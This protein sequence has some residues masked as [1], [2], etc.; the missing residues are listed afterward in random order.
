MSDEDLRKFGKAARYMV[1]PRANMGMPPLADFL[2]QLEEARNEW[3]RRKES[4]VGDLRRLIQK[5]SEEV[6][7]ADRQ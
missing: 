7:A 4:A 1:S 6:P 3:R 5:E 2:L